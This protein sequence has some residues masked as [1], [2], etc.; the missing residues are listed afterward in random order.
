MRGLVA[1][2]A[3]MSTVEHLL[4]GAGVVRINPELVVDAARPYGMWL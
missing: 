1:D 2:D 3:R 4:P